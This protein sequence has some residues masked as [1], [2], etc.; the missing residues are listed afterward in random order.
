MLNKPDRLE[1][2]VNLMREASV[3]GI[4]FASALMEDPVIEN[5]LSSRF[6]LVLIAR[7][8]KGENFNYVVLDNYRGAYDLTRHLIGLGYKK[9]AIVTGPANVSTG[10]DRLR[11]FREALKHNNI[12]LKDEYVVQCDFTRE[13]GYSATKRLLGLKERPEAIFEGCDYMAMGGID[14]IE[15]AG[16]RVPEDIA[17]VGFDETEFASNK[18]IRLTTVSQRKYEMGKLAVQILIEQIEGEEKNYVHKIV[19]DPEL[20][21]RESCGQKLRRKLKNTGS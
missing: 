12:K 17:L 8:L 9:I 14:A 4:I 11:G 13:S 19:L 21:V 6:P 2:Y 3:D 20:I 10:I 15:E 5:L 7:K 18:R 1:D 16:L